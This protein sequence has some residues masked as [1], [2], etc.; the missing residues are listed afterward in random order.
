MQGIFVL[1]FFF[2]FNKIFH[3]KVSVKKLLKLFVLQTKKYVS[4]KKDRLFA[5][6]FVVFFVRTLVF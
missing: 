5:V 1:L 3:G 4:T 6:F 2:L